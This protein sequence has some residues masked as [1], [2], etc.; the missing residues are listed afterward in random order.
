MS[1]VAS[2]TLMQTSS[3][4]GGTYR[5]SPFVSPPAVPPGKVY[6]SMTPAQVAQATGFTPTAGPGILGQLLFRFGY[7]PASELGKVDSQVAALQAQ[8]AAAQTQVSSL[9]SQLS[10]LAS[11][12]SQLTSQYNSLKSQVSS[13]QSQLASLLSQLTALQSQYSGLES[14]KATLQSDLASLQTQWANLQATLAQDATTISGL[15]SQLSS[16]QSQVQSYTSISAAPFYSATDNQPEAGKV[17]GFGP[18]DAASN[19]YIGWDPLPVGLNAGFKGLAS[20][21]GAH[22]VPVALQT[23]G[24]YSPGQYLANYLGY[25]PTAELASAADAIP[26]LQD[27][28]TSLQSQITTLQSEVSTAQSAIATLQSEITQAKSTIASLQGQIST[29]NSA[30]STLKGEVSAIQQAIANLKSQIATLQSEISNGT[31]QHQT[32][33]G[34]I[35]GLQNQVAQWQAWLDDI[36][37]GNFPV[38]FKFSTGD[39]STSSNNTGILEHTYHVG[40]FQPTVTVTATR[41]DGAVISHTFTIGKFVIGMWPTSL[42]APWA[43]SGGNAVVT[44]GVYDTYGSSIDNTL[45]E[46]HLQIWVLYVEVD[47]GR[48][49]ARTPCTFTANNVEPTG[50][51]NGWKMTLRS[52]RNPTLTATASDGYNG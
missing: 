22:A 48:A 6:P 38:S 52:I 13:L 39:G 28:L 37:S 5:P 11:Q 3:A 27:Q 20:T 24:G 4:T 19:G 35:T 29:T 47:K 32:N 41:P 7:I 26:G 25:V 44:P 12:Q 10:T 8:I 42:K 36:K 40:T 30:I 9:T 46:A 33:L 2:R 50:L 21:T 23:S 45:V 1:S 16:L 49:A 34:I 18:D 51:G 17:D 14:T 15:R 43:R 31:S